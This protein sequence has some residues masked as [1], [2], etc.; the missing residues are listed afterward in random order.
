MYHKKSVSLRERT[1][2]VALDV[3][4][5]MFDSLTPWLEWAG[6]SYDDLPVP[7]RDEALDLAPFMES[8]GIADPLEWWKNPSV[9]WLEGFSKS[10]PNQRKLI[11]GFKAFLCEL[12]RAILDNVECDEV[13]FIVVSS[14]FPEHEAAKWNLVDAHLG[15][16]V[17]AKISTSAKH[18]VDFD[19]IID[20]SMGVALN[21][22]RAGKP[23]WM[24]ETPLA[25]PSPGSMATGL[26]ALLPKEFSQLR[27]HNL[28]VLLQRVGI[29]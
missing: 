29:A 22:I 4:L 10:H 23:V 25:N 3:D 18:H 5:T 13:K 17:D 20:D 21:C 11:P 19:L 6:L 1:F 7:E 28:K 16:L 12:K 2:V 27:E 8:R 15:D 26:L 9:Y 14:C 24:V